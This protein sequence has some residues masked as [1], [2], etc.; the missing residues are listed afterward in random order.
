MSQANYP[1]PNTLYP[2]EGVKRTVYLK[3]IVTNPQI[4]VG[5]YTYYDDP[6][7][8]HHFE[9]NVLYLFDF[10]GD[11]LIIG[12]FCQIA[13]GVRFIM[14]GA[15]HAMGGVSTYPFKVFGHA[16]GK[17]ELNAKSKGDTLVG[18]DVW[19]GTRATIMPG[20]TIGHGAIIGAN[21]L[22][23]HDVSP[24]TIVGG[25][26]AKEIRKRF[27]DDTIQ[28]LLD[29]KWWDWEIQ[30]ITQHVDLIASGNIDE[31]KRI[32]ENE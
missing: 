31:L 7:D 18:H 20:V 5:D 15:N 1:N 4:I 22:V 24:Y 14:N 26:P 21:A 9:K 27:D 12:R 29:L 30:K 16:W 8:V 23:C 11:R 19:I 2:I 28:F 32:Y 13:A 6:D 17:A 10:I 25:N 3:N